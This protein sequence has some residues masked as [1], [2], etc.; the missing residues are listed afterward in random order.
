MNM[1]KI[2]ILIGL[3]LVFFGFHPRWAYAQCAQAASALNNISECPVFDPNGVLC[4]G[5]TNVKLTPVLEANGSFCRF[6]VDQ[7][8]APN[9]EQGN[10][11]ILLFLIGNN[12]I[13]APQAN[14]SFSGSGANKKISVT[15][16]DSSSYLSNSGL[17]KLQLES[18]SS[19]YSFATTIYFPAGVTVGP[20]EDNSQ[21]ASQQSSSDAD[22]A[23]ALKNA[24]IKQ[25]LDAIK[26][27]KKYKW[28]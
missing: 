3:T 15:Y 14:I 9:F 13:E 10:E 23:K 11:T 5:L 1:K 19:N 16:N 12:S 4:I 26:K 17:D 21:S 18:T 24:A 22:K 27:M 25:K 20:V 8:P 7:A 6:N 28:K 2:M